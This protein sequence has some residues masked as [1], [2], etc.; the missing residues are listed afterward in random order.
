[1][2]RSK[3]TNHRTHIS[4]FNKIP[5]FSVPNLFGQGEPLNMCIIALSFIQDNKT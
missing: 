5:I 1:V 4:D 2:L 3:V